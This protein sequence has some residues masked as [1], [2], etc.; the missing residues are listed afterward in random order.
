MTRGFVARTTG[1]AKLIARA[2]H[3]ARQLGDGTGAQEA[4]TAAIAELRPDGT[5]RLVAG[6]IAGGVK[7]VDSRDE[8]FFKI[9]EDQLGIY[10][11]SPVMAGK[12]AKHELSAVSQLHEV[13]DGAHLTVPL[14][15]CVDVTVRDSPASRVY[16]VQAFSAL[17][18]SDSTLR[19]G[20]D[21]GGRST[22]VCAAMMGP[23]ESVATAFHLAPGRF[24]KGLDAVT[25][26]SYE[27]ELAAERDAGLLADAGPALRAELDTLGVAIGASDTSGPCSRLQAQIEATTGLTVV[28]DPLRGVSSR[29]SRGQASGVGLPAALAGR[30]GHVPTVLPFDVEGHI[31]PSGERCIA[32]THRLC[33][34]EMNIQE[35]R[36]GGIAVVMRGGGG[37]T[38]VATVQLGDND[39]AL[40]ADARTALSAA[41]AAG[42][43]GEPAAT[44]RHMPG[45][46]CV[47]VSWEGVKHVVVVA[48]PSMYW[49]AA[50][51]T[52]LFPPT[53]GRV[54][55]AA[56]AA[57]VNPDALLRGG[58]LAPL[59]HAAL[60]LL[61]AG[62]LGRAAAAV[63]WHVMQREEACSADVASLRGAVK[64]GLHEHGLG[65]RHTSM[66]WRHVAAAPSGCE[67]PADKAQAGSMTGSLEECAYVC[68]CLPRPGSSAGLALEQLMLGRGESAA[69][70]DVKWLAACLAGRASA[71]KGL[72]LDVAQRAEAAQLVLRSASV[73]RVVRSWL[74]LQRRAASSVKTSG[75][76][77]ERQ[78]RFSYTESG[79]AFEALAAGA[80]MS[81]LAELGQ[82]QLCGSG[83]GEVAVLTRLQQLV[84]RELD[85]AEQ[86]LLASCRLVAQSGFGYH[87]LARL[88]DLLF[89]SGRLAGALDAH[90]QCLLIQRIVLG[91]DHPNVA[92]TLSNIGSCRSRMGD[93]SAA[94]ENYEEALEISSAAFGD[95]HPSVATTWYNVGTCNLRMGRFPAALE[96]LERALA[97]QTAVLDDDHPNVGMSWSSI[98][99]CKTSMGDFPGA[100][101]AFERALGIQR[102]TLG[103]EHAEVGLTLNNRGQCRA[104]MGEHEA[105]MEDL[106]RALATQQAAVGRGHAHVGAT[107]FNL[108]TCMTKMGDFEGALEALEQALRIKQAALGSFHA[109]VGGMWFHVGVCKS[110]LGAYSAAA[111]AYERALAIQRRGSI[112]NH[113]N[114][115]T[116]LL[117]IGSCRLHL[118]DFASALE[119]LKQSLT[120]M[121][122][123]LGGEHPDIAHLHYLIGN[124]WLGM[125]DFPAALEAYTRAQRIQ[126]A[127][128]G[129]DDAREGMTWVGIGACRKS[130]E[131]YPAAQEAYERALVIQR[132]RLGEDHLHTGSTWS[133]I[134]MCRMH[135]SDFSGALAP[136]MQAH[137]ILGANLGTSHQDCLDCQRMVAM[138]V[139]EMDS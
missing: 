47:L 98:G 96:A 136:L 109:E 11:G 10:R 133:F 71:V 116:T 24:T 74:L 14:V 126:Q 52:A 55:A 69:A 17:E 40:T 49:K 59:R 78:S 111:E 70:P 15:S 123:E 21:D 114:A 62:N 76:G 81:L 90:L 115:S 79:A 92:L 7:V 60:E 102:A 120:I 8:A 46:G 118:Q 37:A 129:V 38:E 42:V 83:P 53:A 113:A 18:I 93:Y 3:Q 73:G 124:S 19:S 91:D 29:Y 25:V 77:G 13:L 119:A 6:G 65:L 48:H 33:I 127:K 51:L 35:G 66:V 41:A 139:E 43:G 107:W 54:L 67:S 84:H 131:N 75:I 50:H 12:P 103:D 39:A 130:M 58:D 138:C 88:G 1:T 68:S 45:T 104:S 28:L 89:R 95:H 86:G 61:S 22:H 100:L 112:E 4:L 16:R 56:G 128:L 97:A 134:G 99:A 108:G 32:D 20:S 44:V 87:S 117:R 137:E 23:L 85:S 2:Y 34:P 132:A 82:R 106:E 9:S 63:R 64:A 121:Q 57:R 26:H 5:L 94:L 105:A 125:K 122:A 110:R 30:D 101:E 31:L 36:S 80:S 135:R 27:L 72:G